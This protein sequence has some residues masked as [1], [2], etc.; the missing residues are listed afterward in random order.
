MTLR[1]HCSPPSLLLP[2]TGVGPTSCT[3]GEDEE[4]SRTSIVQGFVSGAILDGR[5][6]VAVVPTTTARRGVF[7]SEEAEV[8]V[9]LPVS[10]RLP[11]A[12]G[13]LGEAVRLAFVNSSAWALPP[14]IIHKPI[15]K[16]AA[17]DLVARKTLVV[18]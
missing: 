13:R 2:E 14:T 10:T 9:R 4:L 15:E 1:I 11:K 18:Y 6:C 5:A 16:L 7:L 3:K 12:S 17:T 8:S